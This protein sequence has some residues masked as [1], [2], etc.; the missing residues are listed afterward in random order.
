VKCSGDGPHQHDAPRTT[1]ALRFMAGS[2]A[3]FIAEPRNAAG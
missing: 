2:L 3:R 1:A